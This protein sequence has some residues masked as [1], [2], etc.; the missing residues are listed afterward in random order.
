M[1]DGRRVPFGEVFYL[2]DPYDKYEFVQ[3]PDYD[4]CDGACFGGYRG[5]SH[6]GCDFAYVALRC[7]IL[8]YTRAVYNIASCSAGRTL[9]A[10]G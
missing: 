7:Q 8:P 6:R 1:P 3:T 5:D 2:G 9:L 4:R 10:A